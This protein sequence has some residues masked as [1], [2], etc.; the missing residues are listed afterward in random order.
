MSSK[1][2]PRPRCTRRYCS[3]ARRHPRLALTSIGRRVDLAVVDVA[4]PGRM[5]PCRGGR[6]LLQS[7]L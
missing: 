5:R 4:P 2:L 6:H 7:S 3:A 1:C